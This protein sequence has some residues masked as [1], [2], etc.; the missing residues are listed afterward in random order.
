[1]HIQA[2]LIASGLDAPLYAA[3]PPGDPNRLF[4]LEKNSGRVVILDLATGGL[5]P[6]P[7]FDVPATDLSNEGE[8]GLLG[9][10][11]HPAYGANGKLYLNLTNELGYRDPRIDPFRRFERGGSGKHARAA[12]DRPHE[13]RYQP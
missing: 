5:S 6:Q 10:A 13:R 8:R 3:S 4:V 12:D 1:M 7:F 11:F 9:L 2:D